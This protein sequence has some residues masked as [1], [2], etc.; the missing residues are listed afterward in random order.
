ME[1]SH[2]KS[3]IPGTQ[4]QLR[5][6]AV[7]GLA[8]HFCLPTAMTAILTRHMQDS[9]KFDSGNR[10]IL[11]I[12]NG[13]SPNRVKGFYKR[14]LHNWH[15]SKLISNQSDLKFY[16]WLKRSDLKS[17]KKTPSNRYSIHNGDSYARLSKPTS[18]CRS[19]ALKIFVHFVSILSKG[20]P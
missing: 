1:C 2:S 19:S 8:L 6:L 17:W 14:W 11:F 10:K 5:P 13:F 4:V 18:S 9:R 3:L 16:R 15:R 20:A 7:E 12:M